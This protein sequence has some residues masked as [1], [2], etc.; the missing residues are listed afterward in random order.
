MVQRLAERDNVGNGRTPLHHAA[1]CKQPEGAAAGGGRL[2]LAAG[3]DATARSSARWTALHYAAEYGP[4]DPSLAGVLMGAGCNPAAKNS[5]GRTALDLAKEKNKPRM[6]ALLEAA[7]G[8]PEAT[9]APFRTE[10]KDLLRQG[11]LYVASKLP[12]PEK[13]IAT[14]HMI[15]GLG[16]AD[17]ALP[18]GTRICV[19]GRGRGAYVRLGK[20]TF[21][22]NEHTIAFDSGETA[23]IRLRAGGCCSSSVAEWTAKEAEMDAMDPPPE[24]V[25]LSITV[26][27]IMGQATPL[28][29]QS[30]DT[31]G[32]VKAMIQENDGVPVARQRL[33][34]D[35]TPQEDGAM[36][37]AVGVGDGATIHLVMKADEPEPE[38]EPIPEGV[39]A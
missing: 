5:S 36:L 37:C 10:A 7:A 17:R 39:P 23:T 14:A 25:P 21:G 6:A 13:M 32:A 38:P 28:D 9:L 16:R 35:D 12:E 29:V 30:T 11:M 26:T 8:D 34:F 19:A 1:M 2:L 20:Q 31:I 33:V 27:T 15:D 18:E 4:D 3:A 22:A 24:A